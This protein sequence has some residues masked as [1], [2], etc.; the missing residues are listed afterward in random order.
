MTTA[1][2]VSIDDSRGDK[3]ES[4]S[5]MD[6]DVP[7]V[8]MPVSEFPEEYEEYKEMDEMV[9]GIPLQHLQPL[10]DL[11]AEEGVIEEGDGVGLVPLSPKIIIDSKETK[12]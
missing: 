10:P 1:S 9:P 5:I 12:V 3:A 7:D 4:Q 11:G 2:S 8:P 6:D